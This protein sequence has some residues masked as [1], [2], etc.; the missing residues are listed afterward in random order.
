MSGRSPVRRDAG[1]ERGQSAVVGVAVLLGVTAVSLGLL[2]AG[3]GTLVDG[4]VAATDADR[5]A[6]GMTAALDRT[7]DGP[8]SGRVRFA[9]G[10]LR[11]EERT[12]RLLN[13]SGTVAQQRAD[14][15]V[16]VADGRRVAFVAGAIVEVTAARATFRATPSVT[17]TDGA[18]LVDVP[19][20]NA[21]GPDEIVADRT[22]AVGLR[23]NATHRRRPLAAGTYRLAVETTLPDAWERYLRTDAGGVTRRDFDADGVDSV[24]ARY[25]NV[26]RGYLLV[27]DLRLEVAGD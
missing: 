13:D 1:T 10:R 2:T 15:L 7:A 21:T 12:V 4:H 18:F 22:T 9:T 14:A 25:P 24:V 3:V 6:D 16:Y 11:T 23:T 5:V 27:R 8:A 20:L 26:D 17:A 19:L